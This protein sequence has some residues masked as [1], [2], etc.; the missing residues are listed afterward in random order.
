MTK[1]LSRKCSECETCFT[2]LSKDVKN[3]YKVVY[4][5]NPLFGKTYT[6]YNTWSPNV[7]ITKAHDIEEKKYRVKYVLCPVCKCKNNIIKT[8]V[9]I[10]SVKH[11]PEKRRK[12]RY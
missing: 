4:T 8:M 5:E 1:E 7:E 11:V 2:F 12:V 6:E 9:K 3:T 10:L